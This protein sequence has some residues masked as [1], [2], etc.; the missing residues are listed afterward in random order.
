MKSEKGLSLVEVMLAMVIMGILAVALLGAISGAFSSM[1]IADERVTAESLARSEM[2]YVKN[3]GY[4][5]ESQTVA[6]WAYELPNNPPPWDATHSLP[7]GYDGYTVGVSA[8]TLYV[9]D[10]GIQR[11]TVTVGHLGKQGV[12]TLVDYRSQR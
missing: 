3:L 7:P 11:V 4:D 1:V 10:D 5:D 8:D 2:E 6:P 9:A 12:I